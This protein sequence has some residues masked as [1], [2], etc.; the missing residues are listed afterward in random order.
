LTGS[1]D[2]WNAETRRLLERAYL[3]AQD[4]RAGSGFR[5]DEARWERARK[6]ILG[7]IDRDGALLDVGCANGLLM[8]SLVAWAGEEGYSIEPYGLDLIEPVAALARRRLPRWSQRI[9]AGDVMAWTPPFRFD[10]VRTE[11]ECVLPDRRKALVERDD[12]SAGT[13][14]RSTKLI[15][16]GVRYLEGAVKRLD[17]TQFNLVRDALLPRHHV[18]D[19]D[20]PVGEPKVEQHPGADHRVFEDVVEHRRRRD[21]LRASGALDSVGDSKDMCCVG[22]PGLVHLFAV[23]ELREADGVLVGAEG[24]DRH[25]NRLV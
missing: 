6:P 13:S 22:P 15:H 9:F 25:C 3:T 11:L 1:D 5:G 2:A 21:L 24:L 4:P 20:D 7:A 10:F 18:H 17:R 23:G 16:G 14:S 8:E 12:F 19:L